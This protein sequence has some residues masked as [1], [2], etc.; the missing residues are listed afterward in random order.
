MKPLID[1]EALR[2]YTSRVL[3]VSTRAAAGIWEDTSGPE[4][5]KSLLALG[6]DV[7]APVVV[8]DGW[9]IEKQ[10]KGF[11]ESGVDLVIT[12]GGTGH[13]PNDLTP[14]M[15]KRVI[16]RE[17]P[18]IA[19]AIRAFGVARGVPTAI[20]SRGI[21]GIANETLI[22]NLPGSL[23]GVKDGLDVLKPILL[24]ALDQIHGGDHIRAL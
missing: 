9:E 2:K 10:L 21:A 24:H 23:G 5:V 15:T 14:E 18:G 17:S 4:I 11:V 16:D 19:E 22:I 1:A 6:L 8:P 12:T 3:T 13:T 7:A 20:L